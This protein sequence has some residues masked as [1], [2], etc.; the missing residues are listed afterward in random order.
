M[1]AKA[2]IVVVADDLTGA[3]EMA[4]IGHLS[5]LPTQ[6]CLRGAL[7]KRHDSGLLVIDTDS[8]L[9]AAG[10]ARQRI[11][12]VL[13]NL[14]WAPGTRFY[15]K[16]DS[17]LRG[18]VTV[19]CT[20]MQEACGYQ[21]TLL[22]P[23]NPRKGRCIREGIYTVEGVALDKTPFAKDPDHPARSAQVLELLG[24]ASDR[25]ILI[26]ANKAIPCTSPGRILIANTASETE[27]EFW[28]RLAS[29]RDEL[30]PAG[31]ADLFEAWLEALGHPQGPP[32][33]PPPCTGPRLLVSGS[34]TPE[35]ARFRSE[36]AGKGIAS[37]TLGIDEP[38]K[39]WL[40]LVE[41]ALAAGE[42]AMLA[43]PEEAVVVSDRAGALDQ[44]LC[45][46]L[47]QLRE[48]VFP[49]NLFAEGG[50]TAALTAAALQWD[51]FEVRHVWAVGVVTLVPV[52][53]PERSLTL[54]PGSYVWPEAIRRSILNQHTQA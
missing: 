30:L 16:T 11:K 1:S 18:N 48:G 2:P 28:G 19:E 17:V 22:C 15:K 51:R 10:E 41:Q 44:L 43:T 3:A 13:G 25:P 32:S 47:Q 45:A 42:A 4:A 29:T 40:Y 53:D 54:K 52:K 20:V 49:R 26:T 38:P 37:A 14:Q 27:T 50:A 46:A 35:A 31:G 8:R 9:L 39:N 5:G 7:P 34:L 36:L 12:D 21:S 24:D 6:L 33:P 23:A